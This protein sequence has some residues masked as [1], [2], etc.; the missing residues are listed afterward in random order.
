MPKKPGVAGD[1]LSNR[2]KKP[3][4]LL[5]FPALGTSEDRPWRPGQGMGTMWTK[6]GREPEKRRNT[7]ETQKHVEAVLDPG[8]S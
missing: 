2:H 4:A 8:C 5:L 1:A 3:T 7:Y 6:H